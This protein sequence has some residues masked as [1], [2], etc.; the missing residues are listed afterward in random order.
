MYG[1]TCQKSLNYIRTSKQ[2]IKNSIK[3]SNN[4]LACRKKHFNI[5]S[6]CINFKRKLKSWQE[7]TNYQQHEKTTIAVYGA[8]DQALIKQF[9]GRKNIWGNCEFIIN[10]NCKSCDYLFM[11][12]SIKTDLHINCPKDNTYLCICEPAAVKL[13]HPKYTNQFKHIITFRKVSGYKGEQIYGLPMLP[14]RIGS[15]YDRI[16]NARIWQI[17]LTMIFKQACFC[18]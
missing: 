17:I 12:D 10:E 5:L 11:I 7:E 2:I 8:A 6:F 9:P 15:R 16:K 1:I 3:I 13:Y 18:S 4:H 14:W